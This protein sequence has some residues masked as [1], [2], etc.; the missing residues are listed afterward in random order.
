MA[1]RSVCAGYPST[2]LII[3][4]QAAAPISGPREGSIPR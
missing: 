4:D 2:G 1:S 3:N